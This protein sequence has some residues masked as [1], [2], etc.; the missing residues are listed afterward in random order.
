V[1]LGKAHYGIALEWIGGRNK[2]QFD[3]KTEKVSTSLSLGRDTLINKRVPKQG[4]R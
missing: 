4:R 1:S 3:S 2:W